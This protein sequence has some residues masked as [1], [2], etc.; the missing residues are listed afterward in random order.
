MKIKIC[1]I[2]FFLCFC[3]GIA[4]SENEGTY[5]SRI[6]EY[7]VR[8][9]IGLKSNGNY[10]I[11]SEFISYY[12]DENYNV[13]IIYRYVIKKMLPSGNNTFGLSR[14]NRGHNGG[15]VSDEKID[16]LKVMVNGKNTRTSYNDTPYKIIDNNYNPIKLSQYW[17]Q[18]EKESEKYMNEYMMNGY[19]G[20][21]YFNID[22]SN[23]DEAIIEIDYK[24]KV[25]D[26]IKY[27][28]KPFWIPVSN[29]TEM[30][31][32]IENKMSNLFLSY[33]TECAPM[34]TLVTNV[35]RLE[36]TNQNTVV[37]TYVPGWFA[38]SKEIAI[39]FSGAH[40]PRGS[41]SDHFF[42]IKKEYPYGASYYGSDESGVYLTA[43]GFRRRDIDENISKREL[44]QYELIFLNK[45][46][47]RIMRNTFYAIYGYRFNYKTLSEILYDC[48]YE[49]IPDRW[50]NPNFSEAL[51]SPIER[52][53]I[54]IIQNLEN[55]IQ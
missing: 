27:D 42:E 41:P 31:V 55:M 16:N 5:L 12:F 51:L 35:W 53:N 47:L 1:I 10:I 36:K 29:D 25:G 17:W 23:S 4:Y 40:Q 15:L 21:Y 45:N 54:E 46:Q 30:K 44:R 19:I 33:V 24:T 14:R 28:S 50:Y 13:R 48:I 32:L 11:K 20:W 39:W 18:D 26:G 49:E 38:K 2:L 22:F 6:C 7:D 8:N 43:Y 52:K 9:T 3:T 34:D 37:I